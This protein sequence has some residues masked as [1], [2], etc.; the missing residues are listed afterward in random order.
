MRVEAIPGEPL[1]LADWLEVTMLHFEVDLRRLRRTTPLEIDC[2]E[3]RAFVT[4][5]AFRMANLRLRR[6]P[7][8]TAWLFRPF[9]TSRFLNL[10]TYVKSGGEAGIQFLAEWLS[11]LAS[12]PLGPIA[13][14]LPYRAG[15]LDYRHTE[16]RIALRAEPLFDDAVTGLAKPRLEA[17][18]VPMTE[19]R[20]C[21][22]DSLDEFLMERYTAFTVRGDRR[23][24][25]HIW[26]QPWPQTRCAAMRLE[27]TLF[28][29]A[30]PEL[31]GARLVLA[32]HSAGVRDVWM[33][34]PFDL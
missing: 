22:T 10:R 26:H 15:Q 27:N 17:D 5:V 20:V 21:P 33:S 13:Y 19:P 11:N 30:V 9:T 12:V 34:R 25:F 23:R 6:L 3:G 4:L 28:G 24:R 29:A 31:A 18:L 14:G 2:F 32:H 1:F 16:G 7:N 8:L